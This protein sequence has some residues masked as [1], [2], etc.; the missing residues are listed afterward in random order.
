MIADC[1]QCPRATGISTDALQPLI[2]Q[3]S[4]ANAGTSSDTTPAENEKDVAKVSHIR[5]HLV[6]A[7]VFC[8]FCAKLEARNKPVQG[9]SYMHTLQ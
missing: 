7:H 6:R 4:A 9:G 3:D 1:F 2:F 8:S 5:S